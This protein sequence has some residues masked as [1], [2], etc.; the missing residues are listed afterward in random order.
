MEK[1]LLGY[2][3]NALPSPKMGGKDSIFYCPF[4]LFDAEF[5]RAFLEM[6]YTLY[7]SK[8]NDQ[9]ISVWHTLANAKNQAM[10]LE[11]LAVAQLFPE[12]TENHTIYQTDWYR[13]YQKDGQSKRL[14]T[15]A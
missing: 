13:A 2:G 6:L 5:Q 7:P 3:A 1:S 10:A 12:I 9:I 8:F 11:Y 14:F 4:I 15:Q